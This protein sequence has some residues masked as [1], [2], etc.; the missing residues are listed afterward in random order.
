[1]LPTLR[2]T[3]YDSLLYASPLQI[4]FRL[5]QLSPTRVY[6]LSVSMRQEIAPG[7]LALEIASAF[8]SV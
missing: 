7:G 5:V 6:Y 2:V 8:L 1:M 3:R 4:W